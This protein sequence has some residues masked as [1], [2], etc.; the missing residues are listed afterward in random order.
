ML[1]AE[2]RFLI[3]LKCSSKFTYRKSG[4]SGGG[5][6]EMSDPLHNNNINQYGFVRRS[7]SAWR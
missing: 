4:L 6:E 2:S 3:H 5:D 7:L 1:E